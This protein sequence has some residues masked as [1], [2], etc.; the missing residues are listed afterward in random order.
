MSALTANNV[1]GLIRCKGVS[2]STGEQCRN[3]QREA[4]YCSK[5][6]DQ[7]DLHSNHCIG[8]LNVGR[9]VAAKGSSAHRR[10]FLIVLIALILIIRWINRS[11][12][13][14]LVPKYVNP[15]SPSESIPDYLDPFSSST[16][17][18]EYLGPMSVCNKSEPSL[19]VFLAWP[20]ASKAKQ[21]PPLYEPATLVDHFINT[22]NSTIGA[23]ARDLNSLEVSGLAQWQRCDN[24]TKASAGGT[25]GI[26]LQC[27]FDA[28]NA[29]FFEGRLA[30]VKVRWSGP[31]ELLGSG[32]M[33]VTLGQTVAQDNYER[34]V[35]IIILHQASKYWRWLGGLHIYGTILHIYGTILHEMV[36]AY[37]CLHACIE[38]LDRRIDAAP[39]TW[40][41]TIPS[42][43]NLGH[44]G[45]GPE[46]LR[47]SLALEQAVSHHLGLGAL[48]DHWKDS[49][50]AEVTAV[51][52]F[53][54][55][56]AKL[57]QSEVSKIDTEFDRGLSDLNALVGLQ[58]VA[59]HS[60]LDESVI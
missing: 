35:E 49:V 56:V 58:G 47:M 1:A 2:K 37:F 55:N 20:N 6:K 28:F 50:K 24:D 46:W 39:S 42:L 15:V 3:Q 53:R 12:L 23:G 57:Y 18:P 11:S 40:S 7:E 14:K 60:F 36:H 38:A 27:V 21:I 52:T 41:R 32:G 16:T 54:E 51:K 26:D 31:F 44:T 9:T 19:D 33:Q 10:T 59:L 45:H 8:A 48:D 22:T 25:I 30:P 29:L 17:T 43:R 5:H 13:S 4:L 34:R